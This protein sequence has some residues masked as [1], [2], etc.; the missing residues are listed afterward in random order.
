M[1]VRGGTPAGGSDERDDIVPSDPLS[2]PNIEPRKMPIS[3]GQAIAVIDNDQIAVTRIAR[4]INDNTICRCMYR[5]SI[6]AR[7]IQ[8]KMHFRTLTVE[9]IRSGAIVAGDF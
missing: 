7:D 1:K 4:G 6:D 9:R 5:R 8:T 2:H 3:C